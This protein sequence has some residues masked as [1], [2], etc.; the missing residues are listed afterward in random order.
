ML[1]EDRCV[2]PAEVHQVDMGEVAGDDAVGLCC[3][4]LA[5]GRAAPAGSRVYAGGGQDP[6]ERGRSDL[7]FQPCG[8][9]LDPATPS[10]RILFGRVQRQP[11]DGLRSRR[12]AR[13]VPALAVVPSA[14]HQPPV[15][16][17]H[18]ARR[19]PEHLRPAPPGYQRGW[20]CEPQPVRRLVPHRTRELPTQY[21]VLVPQD[22][23]FGIL[24]RLPAQENSRG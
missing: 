15:L 11:F 2:D 13:P 24:R 1:E 10:A 21:R 6:P 19:H 20:G 14:C 12:P 4:E 3:Q 17:G 9:A 7:M 23:K 16:R 5:P 18:G 8:L 22:Q